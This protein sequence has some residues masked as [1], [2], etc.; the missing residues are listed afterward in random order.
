VLV[1]HVTQ[2][3]LNALWP[4]VFFARG[5]RQAS[6]A[7]IGALDASLAAEVALVARTDPATAG[8]LAPY[9]A[10]CGFATAVNA[11]VSDPGA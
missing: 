9:L 6:L 2:L 5:R 4:A 10:W 8:L 11:A 1:L 7:V 3:T